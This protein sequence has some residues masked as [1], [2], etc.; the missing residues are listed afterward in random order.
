MLDKVKL[1]G[2]CNETDIMFDGVNFVALLYTGSSV[3]TISNGFYHNHF[4]K[5]YPKRALNQILVIEGPAGQTLSYS[6]F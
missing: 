6:G 3:S 4:A 5:K 1:I 2:L